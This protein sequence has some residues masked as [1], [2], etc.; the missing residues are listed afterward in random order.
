MIYIYSV[1]FFILFILFIY[2][3]IVKYNIY[4]MDK[5]TKTNRWKPRQKQPI[6]F[7]HHNKAR[8]ALDI[9]PDHPQGVWVECFKNA[10][11]DQWGVAEVIMCARS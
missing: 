2:L 5:H 10:Y 8:N 9:V 3:V 11:D 4:V 1:Y 7:K 6:T